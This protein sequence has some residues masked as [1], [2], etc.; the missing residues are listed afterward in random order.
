MRRVL[1]GEDGPLADVTALN[2]A[3]AL[4]V[5]GLA[6]NL[7]QGL[8]RARGALA[9]GAAARKLEELRAFGEQEVAP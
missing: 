2:A 7:A 6:A 8:E 9:S 1:G 5:A 4:Y 3:A